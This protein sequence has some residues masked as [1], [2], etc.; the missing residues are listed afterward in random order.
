MAKDFRLSGSQKIMYSVFILF[1]I[2]ILIFGVLCIVFSHL[3]EGVIILLSSLLIGICIS[4]AIKI[5]KGKTQVKIKEKKKKQ[6]EVNL[7]TPFFKAM[8]VKCV[9]DDGDVVVNLFGYNSAF[10][11]ESVD[12]NG[13][14]IVF[15]WMDIV[16]YEDISDDE[17]MVESKKNGKFVFMFPTSVKATVFLQ[18]CDKYCS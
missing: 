4:E 10:S 3:I 2:V 7:G 16:A 12:G 5:D 1:L 11:V 6:V 14:K 18:Y 13:E 9:C 15:K 8:D 17:I